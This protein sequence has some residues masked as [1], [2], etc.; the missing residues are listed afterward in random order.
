MVHKFPLKHRFDATA[1]PIMH[2]KMHHANL[3][4]MHFAKSTA[5][6]ETKDDI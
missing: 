1:N 4:W 2:L 3:A 5:E 6:E